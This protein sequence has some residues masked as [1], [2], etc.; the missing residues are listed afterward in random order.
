MNIYKTIYNIFNKFNSFKENN[1]T[2]NIEY[3]RKLTKE[4]KIN[5]I[6]KPSL[7][8]YR[9]ELYS[10]INIKEKYIIDNYIVILNNDNELLNLKLSSLHPNADNDNYFCLSEELRFK[11]WNS[12]LKEIINNLLSTYNI[13]DCYFN[14]MCD[15]KLKKRNN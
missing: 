5:Q 4:I 8:I 6:I 11:K 2:D 10:I 14:P 13:D 9:K 12:S 1:K 3:R 15:L 7:L